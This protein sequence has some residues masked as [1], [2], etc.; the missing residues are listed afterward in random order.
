MAAVGILEVSA[1]AL[2]AHAAL[3]EG[4]AVDL[5]GATTPQCPAHSHQATTAAVAAAHGVVDVA[6]TAMVARMRSTAAAVHT[7]A[8]AFDDHEAAAAAALTE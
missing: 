1:T 5:G 8:T 7:V 4:L 3:C 2:R 6:R